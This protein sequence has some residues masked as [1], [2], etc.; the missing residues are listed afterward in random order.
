MTNSGDTLQI[1]TPE[2]VSFDYDVSGIG[3]R[4]MAALVDT[5]LIALLQALL[6]GAALLLGQ[7]ELDS[8]ALSSW[9]VA[10]FGLLAFV[11]FWGYYIF[12]EILWNGQTPG[13]R[14]VKLRVQVS[15]GASG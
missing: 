15:V 5:L 8:D 12:F 3:S 11:F 14:W 7:F 6:S 13:K 4:F 10:V 9:V 1:D 2:N